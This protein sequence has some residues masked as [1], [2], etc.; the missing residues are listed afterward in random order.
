[1]SLIVNNMNTTRKM[2]GIKP[3]TLN[4]GPQHPAAH[5]VLR[6]ILILD[7]EVIVDADPHI[8]LLHR[9]TEKLMEYKTYL[10]A[11]PYLDRLD[12]VSMMCQ[13][14][15]YIYT[16]NFTGG[17]VMRKSILTRRDTNK[18]FLRAKNKRCFSSLANTQKNLFM[19]LG[20]LA[21]FSS[22]LLV[23][24][25]GASY[26][27]IH[28]WAILFILTI[29]LLLLYFIILHTDSS[30]KVTFERNLLL[31][32]LGFVLS[33]AFVQTDLFIESW[34]ILF[35]IPVEEEL[36]VSTSKTEISEL[37]NPREGRI[38][39]INQ[40]PLQEEKVVED[41]TDYSF[42]PE[43]SSS[44]EIKPTPETIVS[45]NSN[46]SQLPTSGGVIGRYEA[47]LAY[48]DSLEP[49]GGV[50]NGCVLLPVAQD[51]VKVTLN[52]TQEKGVLVS[53]NLTDN[54]SKTP[55][56][57]KASLKDSW[58]GEDE[59][60]YAGDGKPDGKPYPNSEEEKK[61]DS[62]LN[63]Q[64]DDTLSTSKEK[65]TIETFTRKVSAPAEAPKL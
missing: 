17:V 7:G 65:M 52:V 61:S 25:F 24:I 33:L 19:F 20:S 4:F 43:S 48:K 21:L 44:V 63:I 13:E 57:T 53:I 6:L 2:K 40:T 32:I 31:A 11:L 16:R 54:V 14:H 1:M 56:S 55:T 28:Y 3:Y 46:V 5:G 29:T 58:G 9:G 47:Y 39:N 37:K 27:L 64:N 45:T 22:G 35:P 23:L 41:L 50:V 59:S 18:V 49:T 60:K 62:S 10:Q 15:S 34:M 12:Y 26:V 30:N 36:E 42:S 8:G 51:V 38:I